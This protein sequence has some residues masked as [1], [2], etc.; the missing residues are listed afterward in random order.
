M[1][2]NSAV[3]RTCRA[4]LLDA[5]QGK[6]LPHCPRAACSATDVRLRNGTSKCHKSGGSLE[7]HYVV[8]ENGLFTVKF[9]KKVKRGPRRQQQGGPATGEVAATGQL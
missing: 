1:V 7:Q 4:C 9:K 3:Y 8:I 2:Q 5:V 6:P